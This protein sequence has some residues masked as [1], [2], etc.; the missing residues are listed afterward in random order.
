M[1]STRLPGKALREICGKPLLR[2]VIDRLSLAKSVDRLVVATSTLAVND[3]IAAFCA[4]HGID[5]FRGAEADVL[6]RT[7]EAL[8]FF[9]A[10]T[11]IVAYG[12]GPL[13]DPG[14]VDEAVA[15]FRGTHPAADFLGN[16]LKTTY[17]P[18]M[19]VEVFSVRAL[20]DA[21]QRCTDPAVRE[22]G[23]LYLRLNPQRYS[24]VSMEAPRELRRPE[25]ELEVDVEEDVAVIARILEFFHDRPDFTLSDI[26]SF[27]DAHP[28]IAAG[29]RA[30]SRRW[31]A[32]R[33]DA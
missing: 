12:D 16:D 13:I 26:V 25:L 15:R 1:G 8:Q 5:C 3:A 9:G 18:G 31:K 19:E 17:P 21:N 7:A 29:N 28:E 6:A 23:T 20:V 22:H 4:A 24:L 2:H 11:G 32:F 33:S 14:I 30:I 27:L 10:S